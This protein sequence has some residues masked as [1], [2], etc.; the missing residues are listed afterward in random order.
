M[1][2]VCLVMASL[3]TAAQND[4]ASLS[5]NE[6][7]LRQLSPTYLDGVEENA[8]WNANW[9]VTLQGGI[10]AFVGTPQGHGDLFDR[11]L[12]L[13][14]ASLGKWIKPQVA[15]RVAY[16]GWQL[17]D[18]DIEKRNF[19][20]LHADL[21]Y[22][23]AAHF[24]SNTDN[25]ARWDVSPYVGLGIIKNDYTEKKPFAV[26]GGLMVRYR[27]ARRL[28]VSAELG[29]TETF[30]DFDGYGNDDKF[31]DLLAHASIGL[32]ATL[33]KVGWQK[34]VDAKPYIYQNDVLLE[35]V[36]H[37]QEENDRLDRM[38]DFDQQAMAEMRKILEIEGLLGK[39]RLLKDETTE[40]YRPYP[41]NDYS[42]LNSLRARIRNRNW[43]GDKENYVP[44]LNNETV[45]PTDTL[46][47]VASAG[48]RRENGKEPVGAPIFFFFRM[49]T[50]NLTEESQ[51]V[52]AKEIA[53]VAN[54]HGLWVR[55]IGAADKQ[56]GT[57]QA[58]EILSAKRADYIARIL[59][60]NGVDAGHIATQTAGGISKYA[61]TEANRNT[62]VM[63]YM[64]N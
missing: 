55:I 32:S 64:Q 40:S 20:N 28:H 31:G 34:I 39:Y 23:V 30:Q 4:R 25:L 37:L 41:R 36:S 7:E 11:T 13:V 33:G 60:E 24:R 56:T 27:F 2:A 54:K 52:N 50:N 14:N 6:E 5:V 29:V 35:Y 19:F 53:K 9:F 48:E 1:S 15:V 49:N 26:S 16:Q 57:P 47:S 42:G 22:N 44:L 21:L 58:N 10:S 43:N 62:C 12:P 3:P 8:G 61:P 17:Y 63:L 59:R 46:A 38:H 51:I 45:A 18:C